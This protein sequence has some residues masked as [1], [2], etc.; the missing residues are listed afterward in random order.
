MESVEKDFTM[1]LGLREDGRGVLVIDGRQ[2]LLAIFAMCH[3]YLFVFTG[4]FTETSSTN[5][6]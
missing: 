5:N 4:P 3:M 6:H 1:D 2:R